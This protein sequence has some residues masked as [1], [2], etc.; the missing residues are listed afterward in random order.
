MVSHRELHQVSKE[1]NP[2]WYASP[3]R[4]AVLVGSWG[5]K[6][7]EAAGREGRFLGLVAGARGDFHLVV[8]IDEFGQVFAGFD[9]RGI[10]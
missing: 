4:A 5:G 3:P 6:A 2:L 1:E 8:L 10:W 7:R 9:L